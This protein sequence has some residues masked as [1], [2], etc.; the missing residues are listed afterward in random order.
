M[1]YYPDPFAARLAGEPGPPPRRMPIINRGTWARVAAMDRVVED[2]LCEDFGGARRQVVSLGAGLDSR[3]FR[4]WDRAQQ[5]GGASSPAVPATVAA[6]AAA[7]SAAIAARAPLVVN[8]KVIHQEANLPGAAVKA[9]LLGGGA[10][11]GRGG[12]GSGSGGSGGGGAAVERRP[13]AGGMAYFEVDFPEVVSRKRKAIHGN[14]SLSAAVAAGSPSSLGVVSSGGGESGEGGRSGSGGEEDDEDEDGG[15]QRAEA[16][17]RGGTVAATTIGTAAAPSAAAGIVA[18][19]GSSPGT[20]SCA[21]SYALVAGDLRDVAALD[22]A[23]AVA[24]LDPKLPTLFIAECV[25]VYLEPAAAAALL[26]WAAAGN[27]DGGQGGGGEQGGELGGEPGSGDAARG[28]AFFAAFDM[29]RPDDA[30]GA[31]MRRN[32]AARGIVLH[33]MEAFPDLASQG[34]RFAECGGGGG[35]GGVGWSGGVAAADM[36]SVYSGGVSGATAAGRGCDAAAA[37]VLDQAEVARVERLEM[38]DELEEWRMLMSHYCLVLAANSHP[39]ARASCFFACIAR[40][41]G[42][43]CAAAAA[44]KPEAPSASGAALPAAAGLSQAQDAQFS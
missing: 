38:L 32:L 26:A 4:L 15:G 11:S 7:V 17:V 8:G 44:A 18:A 24:G 2:F 16:A 30:F 40:A 33:G 27:F 31:V 3:F 22:A 35:G 41:L 14:R 36:L 29:V 42:G 12:D 10:G 21:L 5:P 37:P 43:T 28:P 25:L 23:L 20:P 34:P 1:R 6:A 13:W 39:A 9:A 19:A